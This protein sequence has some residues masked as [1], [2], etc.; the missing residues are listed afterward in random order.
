MRTSY[1][2]HYLIFVGIISSK[3][4]FI[5]RWECRATRLTFYRPFF[6]KLQREDTRLRN[7][8]PP[9]SVLAFGLYRLSHGESKMQALQWMLLV[10]HSLM[11]AILRLEIKIKFSWLTFSIKSWP[12][13]WQICQMSRL[14]KICPASRQDDGA[15]EVQRALTKFGRELVTDFFAK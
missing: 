9:E 14:T 3:K 15:F 1:A 13:N 7:C 8:I 10:K 12:V 6:V 2:D 4:S 5:A 11:S